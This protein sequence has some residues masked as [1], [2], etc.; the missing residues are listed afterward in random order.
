MN[1]LL[2][3]LMLLGGAGSVDGQL[4]WWATTNQFG[5]M[6]E[7]N[8]ALALVQASTQFDP[9]KE[10]QW[11]WGASLGADYEAQY[12]DTYN[13]F[14]DELYG[15][16]KWKVLTLD[17]GPKRREMDFLGADPT[18]GSLSVTGGHVIES[19]NARTMP[20]YN[21]SHDPVPIPWTDEKLRVWGQWGDYWTMDQR[22][23]QDAL[24]HRVKLGLNWDIT[25]HL[26]FGLSLDHYAMWGGHH[27]KV[28]DMAVNLENYLRLVLG[29]H[30]G[31][32]GYKADRT[33]VIGDHGGGEMFNLVYRGEGWKA[34]IRHDIPYSDG[35]G[36][37]FLNFP[38]GVNTMHFGFDKKE[39]WISDV[40][41]EYHYTMYQSGPYHTEIFDDDGN[42]LTPPG[43]STTGLDD[44][45]NNGYY[46]S[47]WTHFGRAIGT[48]LCMPAGTRDGSWWNVG[49]DGKHGIVKGFESNRYK[50]HHI[51]LGGKLWRR[52]PYRLMLTYSKHYGTYPIPY[53]GETPVGKPW[54]SVHET[55]LRQF[56]A[57]F[58]GSFDFG[59][60]GK[61]SSSAKSRG[62]SLVYGLYYDR[63]ELLPDNVGATLGL[64]YTL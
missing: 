40:V 32:D 17:A 51:G 60:R 29:L 20:G 36:M 4:P 25:P 62:L 1:D 34:E 44:Y 33:N 8:G 22:Y 42:S 55:G 14:V 39:R 16:L 18:L 46:Q 26:T 7:S 27:P 37:G 13:I 23:V 2:L 11:R 35:S 52:H 41:Y 61:C 12:P 43:V 50:A 21:I 31:A 30:A 48:P 10:L 28:D 64:R 45:F 57:G 3:S 58:N 19:G 24:V 49:E 5:I 54:G 63:G 47:G 38:D 59:R 56:S 15:S 9:D 53:I 6:P